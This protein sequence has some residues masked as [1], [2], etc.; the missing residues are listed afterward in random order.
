[1][2]TCPHCTLI[3]PDSATHCDCGFDFA[4]SPAEMKAESRKMEWKAAKGVPLGLAILILALA[5]TLR[6][7][8]SDNPVIYFGMLFGG[9]GLVMASIK[10]IAQLRDADRAIQDEAARRPKRWRFRRR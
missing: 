1:M 8:L 9:A 4:S 5:F 6:A 7:A 3:S 10:R 2:K